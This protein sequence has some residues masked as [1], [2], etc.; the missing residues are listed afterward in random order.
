[1][2]REP[3][4]DGPATAQL[5]EKCGN[6]LHQFIDAAAGL[7]DAQQASLGLMPIEDLTLKPMCHKPSIFCFQ[8]GN[9]S[10]KLLD[11]QLFLL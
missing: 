11:L 4:T 6:F 9:F 5:L 2:V 10:L 3:D 8:H 7:A 1:M